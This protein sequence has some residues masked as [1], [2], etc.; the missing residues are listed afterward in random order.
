MTAVPDLFGILDAVRR[1]TAPSGLEG[2]HIDGFSWARNGQ[3]YGASTKLTADDWN[4][5]IGNLRGVLIGSGVDLSTLDPASPNLLR[6]V[7]VA[8]ILTKLG[9]VLPDY[10]E[11]NAG[12]VADAIL[13]NPAFS[14]IVASALGALTLTFAAATADA[15]PGAGKFRLSN[16]VPASAT[17][18]YVDNLDA[19]GASI[20][21]VLDGWDDSTS[22]IRGMLTVISRA[23]AAVRYTYNVTGTVVDGTGYRK[24]T[25][26]YVAGSGA[27]ADGDGC[28]LVFSRTGDKGTGDFNG[29][30]ASVADNIVTFNG[31][32]GKIGKDSG[33]AV[34]SLAPKANPTFTGTPAVPTATAGTNTTQAA[35]TAFVTA[36]ISAVTSGYQAASTVL[37]AL[38]GIGAAVAGDVIYATGAGVWG[39]LA[40]GTASQ[41][42]LMNP[43][44]TAPQWA[45]LPFTKSFESAPQAFNNGSQ[46]ILP[47]GLGA[48]PKLYA[49]V[50]QCIATD[51]TTNYAVGDEIAIP[52]STD[53]SSTRGIVLVPGSVNM[54]AQIGASGVRVLSKDGGNVSNITAGNWRLVVRAWA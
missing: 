27:L 8:Y 32:S 18:A 14:G 2:V 19:L 21:A 4:R 10:I 54:Y 9:E 5:I 7:M 6:D 47:H 22:T 38:A 45:T 24:L 33:V 28:W 25:L 15:D 23:N 20:T 40:K 42:L 49:A 31:T 1:L 12:D 34:S 11:D 52:N 16:A 48:A 50:I 36:A 53:S 41:A 43:G 35:S 3:S 29:P 37:S 39:R 26:A 13:A 51:G 44:A 30:A 17:A 46:I